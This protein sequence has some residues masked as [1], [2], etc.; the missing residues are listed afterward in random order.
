MVNKETIGKIQLWIGI[1][2]LLISIIGGILT[3]IDYNNLINEYSLAAF[4]KLETENQLTWA[5]Q[6]FSINSTFIMTYAIAFI[7]SLL[8]SLLFITQGMINLKK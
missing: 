7:N 4:N 6:G 5:I 2:L 8:F 3:Y 1:I